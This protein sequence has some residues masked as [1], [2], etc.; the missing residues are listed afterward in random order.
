MNCRIII[1]GSRFIK[2]LD[3]TLY[4]SKVESRGVYLQDR[5]WIVHIY[6]IYRIEVALDK[7]ESVGGWR[8]GQ[9]WVGVV[10]GLHTA[11]PRARGG[12]AFPQTLL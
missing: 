4:S 9:G 5:G 8:E 2:I 12:C 6:R 7:V 11:S 10:R 3:Q 1:I